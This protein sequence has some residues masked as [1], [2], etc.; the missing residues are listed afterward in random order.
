MSVYTKSFILPEIDRREVM[1]YAG[2]VPHSGEEP[3]AELSA[4]LDECIAMCE[5]TFAT[6]VCYC[7]AKIAAEDACVD[8]GFCKVD[9]RHLSKNLVGCESAVIFAATAGNEIDR[10]IAKQGVISP[11]RAV[12]LN[13]V[14]AERIEALC[15]EF[16]SEIKKEKQALGFVCVPRFSPGYGDLPLEFQKDIFALLD[17]HKRIGLTLNESLLMS[18][19]KSVTAIIGVKRK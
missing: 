8:L 3:S 19:S 5:S 18:P 17:C 11:A 14:G 10:L 9:S 4:I 1:R 7:E 12:I 6:R 13:A 16:N 2:I 15:E